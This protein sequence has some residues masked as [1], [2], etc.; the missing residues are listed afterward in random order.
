[1]RVSR[2]YEKPQQS[3]PH[4]NRFHR[5]RLSPEDWRELYFRLKA[6]LCYEVRH[7]REELSMS[8]F[9]VRWEGKA[10]G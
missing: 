8:C 4:P 7:F 3:P 6:V 10:Q 2:A 5:R 9:K 1:M